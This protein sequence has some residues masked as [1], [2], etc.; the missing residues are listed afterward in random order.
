M[1]SAVMLVLGLDTST[2]RLDAAVVSIEGTGQSRVLAKATVETRRRMH[3][4]LLPGVLLDLLEEGGSSL[5]RIDG[6]AIGLGPGSFTGL[7]TGLST[8][9]SMAYGGRIPLEG[10]SSLES[11]ALAALDSDAMSRMKRES[12]ETLLVPL[13][14]ARR[15]RVYAG[16]YRTR[17]AGSSSGLVLERERDD[18]IMEADALLDVVNGYED[19]AVLF[20]SGVEACSVLAEDVRARRDLPMSP[21]AAALSRLCRPGLLQKYAPERVFSVRPVYLRQARDLY[22]G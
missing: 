1:L 3:S 17:P 7:R 21:C 12:K 10:A 9:A 15:G 8:L 14:D 16:F 22:R 18:A 2:W 20:G 11:M 4:Q 19:T 6:L 5:D 13:Q